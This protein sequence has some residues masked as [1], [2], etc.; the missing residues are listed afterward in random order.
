VI[1]DWKYLRIT[2]MKLKNK[3]RRMLEMMIRKK[4]RKLL[5]EMKKM[6][7]MMKTQLLTF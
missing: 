7:K 2:K 1:K 5:M 3:R 6:M 4:M